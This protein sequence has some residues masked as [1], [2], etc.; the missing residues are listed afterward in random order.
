DTFA[1]G[2]AGFYKENSVGG[3]G[4]Y[5]RPGETIYDNVGDFLGTGFLQKYDVSLS[6]GTD[7]FSS[8]AS[9]AYMK[10][11][12]VV[13]KD[14][15]EQINVF[16]KGNFQ[17]SQQVKAQ[18]SANIINTK[19]RGFGNAMSTIYGWSINKNMSDYQTEEGMPNWSN[20][21][22]NWDALSGKEKIGATLSPYFGRYNDYSLTES[23]RF[24]INGNVSYEPIKNLVFTGKIGYDRGYTTY[25]SYTVSRYTKE[26][27]INP[28]TGGYYDYASDYVYRFGAYTF[29][30]SR[31][32]QF[33]AQFLATYTHEF[34][35]FNL[36][37]LYGMEY[38]ENSS[39][40]AQLAG[41]DFELGGGYYSFNNVD[42][43]Y[44]TKSGSSSYNMYLYHT[45]YNKY[46]YFGEIRLDY[47]G[48]AQLSVTGRYDGSSRLKQVDC[49]YFY[50]SVTGGLIFSELFNIKNDW[51]SYGKIRGNWAK[52]GKDCPANLFTNTFK[53]W[54]TFPDGGYGID[55][56]TSRAIQLEP[57]MTSSWEIGADLRFFNQRTRLDIAYYSTVVDNQ[58]VSV[59]V[60]PASG[61]IL[62]TRNEGKIE[63]YGVEATLSQD[64]LKGGD[65]SWTAFA[66]FSFNR[67]RVLSLPDGITEIQGGQYGDIFASAFLNGS[68]TAITGKDY[69]R[70]PSGDVI[71]DENGYPVISPNKQNLI[72]NREPDFLLGLGSNFNWKNL[73][74]S[75][76]VDGRSGGDVVN[77]T[78][79]GL[80]SNGQHHLYSK[81]RNREYVFNGVVA[82]ADGSYAPNTQPVILDQY[83]VNN[84]VYGVSSNFIEDG[85]YIRLSY[86]TVGYDFS[87]LLKQGC[88]VKGLSASLTGRN[89][90]LLTKYSGS[91]P[92]IMSGVSGG[93]GSMGIDNYSVPQT[94]SFNLTLKATF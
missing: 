66:N 22:D 48:M 61:T 17:P 10:N 52:V 63:N 43:A 59:R 25:D 30:P 72:G 81:Y 83:T 13:D 33:T 55:P 71:I 3:W 34:G 41:Q 9:A 79:R 89:L 6:G 86:V 75:F 60:S 51:F 65:F 28:E 38:K 50:P 68:T 19:G 93:T 74:V 53:Q 18:I 87:S 92:Q 36:N 31:G 57:E 11:E 7:K 85:S 2:S 12:G 44:F 49:T 76:L 54:S 5:L 45:K 58:I 82:Q 37:L 67:G 20:R 90:F 64:I 94:R 35:D 1:A 26:D 91:D 73:S 40:E 77:V 70:T 39:Y 84:Y 80:I 88:P 15:K 46:G 32:E 29:Q 42:P 56:T 47:R 78:G 8:Y 4:P 24:M 27:F 62:Q 23:T 14:Y 69:Q 16:V 21:Y